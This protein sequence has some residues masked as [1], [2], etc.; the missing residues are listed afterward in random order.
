MDEE[1]NATIVPSLDDDTIYWNGA[2]RDRPSRLPSDEVTC[3]GINRSF[4]YGLG[5]YYTDEQ[6][7][8]LDD[9]LCH[10]FR[11][12][13]AN[14][15]QASHPNPA[16]DT[17]SHPSSVVG[18]LFDMNNPT[19]IRCI[20]VEADHRADEHQFDFMSI[21]DA[22][23]SFGPVDEGRSLCQRCHD[24]WRWI[25]DH[26]R[27][28]VEIRERGYHPATRLSILTRSASLQKRSRAS[29]CTSAGT[30]PTSASTHFWTCAPS[31]QSPTCNRPERDC[32]THLLL[33][34]WVAGASSAR[35]TE[36]ILERRRGR[37]IM[38]W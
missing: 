35:E 28:N 37:R 11:E 13:M 14:R 32:L 26:A 20:V 33:D 5:D 3:S 21:H 17:W 30:G 8:V 36:G 25:K 9:G 23:C 18:E 22:H 31:I 27:R 10:T 29:R 34:R 6:R 4:V 12:G 15:V 1:A 19:D 38:I 2:W 24:R 16:D 7:R